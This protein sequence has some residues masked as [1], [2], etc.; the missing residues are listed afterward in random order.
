V[1]RARRGVALGRAPAAPTANAIARECEE[2]NERR[3]ALDKRIL[4]EA[5]DAI[6][7]I[8]LDETYGL[9]LHSTDWHAGVIGIVASRVVESTG[10]P[11]MMIAV[12]DGVGKGSGR[13]TGKFDL[14]A[15]LGG[16]ADLLVKHGGH[17]AAAGLT[18]E[19]ARIPEFAAR[20]NEIARA[21]LTRDDLVPELRTD[22]ELP[23]EEADES[24]ER[25]LRFLE[26]FGVG[27]PGPVLVSRGVKVHGGPRRVGTDGLKLALAT[28]RGALEAVAWGMAHRAGE[29][30]RDATIDIAYRLEMNEYRGARTLQATLLDIRPA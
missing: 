11:T 4:D 1:A 9:V 17:R 12:Q 18:I 21:K 24:L 23:I 7:R 10:R 28:P 13:S 2:L 20:F 25:A 5:H 3:Q 15:A 27:N 22:L 29:F 14:H 19:A 6:A 16:C 26:P 8:D 30:G